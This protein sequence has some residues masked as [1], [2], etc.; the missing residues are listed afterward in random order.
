MLV[1]WRRCHIGE[2]IA[3]RC[4]RAAW[5]RGWDGTIRLEV[6]R[7]GSR[8]L[9][10]DRAD[11]GQASFYWLWRRFPISRPSWLSRFPP[12]LFFRSF[13]LPYF[14]MTAGRH[15]DAVWI[16][17]WMSSGLDPGALNGLTQSKV[18]R[19][20][21]FSSLL[22][23]TGALLFFLLSEVRFHL[24]LML[25]ACGDAE[26]GSRWLAVVQFMSHTLVCHLCTVRFS[27]RHLSLK[28][29]K[30]WIHK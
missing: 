29:H 8:W 13:I 3:C 20:I 9:L 22:R 28:L 6:I 27:F 2:E 18:S 14:R 19:Y 16:S 1:V 4:W 12:H 11:L 21:S 25:K 17:P 15:A 10:S 24:G 30:H 5:G 23:L 26:T 7:P